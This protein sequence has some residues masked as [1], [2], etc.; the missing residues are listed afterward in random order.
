[1]KVQWYVFVICWLRILPKALCQALGDCGSCA[2]VFHLWEEASCPDVVAFLKWFIRKVGVDRPIEWCVLGCGMWFVI[3]IFS[4][5]Y[6]YREWASV[7]G[8]HL[9][10]LLLLCLVLILVLGLTAD[11]ALWEAPCHLDSSGMKV[12]LWVVLV[13]PGHSEDHAL[14]SKL[15][16]CQQDVFG[17]AFISYDHVDHLVD[18]SSFI[19]CSIYIVNRNWLGQLL[20]WQFG[21]VDKILINEVSSCASI[22]HGLSGSFFHG[23]CH[24]KVDW[25]HNTTWVLL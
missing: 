20:H 2:N 15:G 23:V 1:M 17:V 25:N 6:E 21:L 8:L 7:T 14:L 9:V 18:A 22:D 4:I 11:A 5:F 13:E 16:D 12:D 3:F 10:R 24:F 19:Q